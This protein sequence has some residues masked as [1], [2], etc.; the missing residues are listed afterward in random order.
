GGGLEVAEA[1]RRFRPRIAAQ[2]GDPTLGRVQQHLVRGHVGRAVGG[3][4][5]KHSY[6]VHRR[7]GSLAAFT[8]SGRLM[9]S[10]CGASCRRSASSR[11]ILA[12]ASANASSVS[13]LSV[14]VGSIMIASGTTSGK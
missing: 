2:R 8:S 7:I 1:E 5:G 4:E 13:L 12:N 9:H 11:P 3:L 10:V 14:S 6:F